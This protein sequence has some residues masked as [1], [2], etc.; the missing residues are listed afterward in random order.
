MMLI[1][2]MAIRIALGHKSRVGKDSFAE[3]LGHNHYCCC[4]SFAQK[5]YDITDLI[6]TALNKRVEKDPA[7]LQMIGTNLKEYYG[8]DVW[9]KVVEERIQD[10]LQQND[11]ANIIITDMR[12]PGE[13]QMLKKYGF[14]TINIIRPNRP[15]DRDPE[16]ISE[17]ALD[18]A[19]YDYRIENDG[20]IGDYHDKIDKVM[21]DIF[22][23]VD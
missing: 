6:Q 15:I 8:E 19:K 14:V 2:M 4:L 21:N 9:I 16:H 13:M 22:A 18:N 7:L 5:L 3:Y 1:H 12:F 17:V 20:A 23:R 10:V 11:R